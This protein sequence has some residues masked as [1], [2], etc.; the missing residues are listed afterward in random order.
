MGINIKALETS[1][2]TDFRT[3]GEINKKPVAAKRLGAYLCNSNATSLLLAAAAASLF[4]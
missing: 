2:T 3:C 1:E 4:S